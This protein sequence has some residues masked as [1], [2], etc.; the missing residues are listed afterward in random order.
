MANII[1]NDQVRELDFLRM[2]NGLTSVFIDTICLAGR[3]L[4]AEDFQKD[5]MIWFAQRDA[6]LMGQGITGFDLVEIA[7]ERSI[8]PQQKEFLLDVLQ[9]ALAKKNWEYLG[10]HPREEWVLENLAGFKRM[11]GE[12][13]GQ[14]IEESSQDSLIPFAGK[15]QKCQ[16]H[17]IYLHVAGCVICNNS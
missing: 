5:L 3:D 14:H 6:R 4:A 7:W 2:S 1:S 12:F 9:L 17:G 8:F 10:Y 16:K 11:L 15:Y 13:E